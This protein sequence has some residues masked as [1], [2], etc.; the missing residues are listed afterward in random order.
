M[1]P[2]A[3]KLFEFTAQW[4][5]ETGVWWCSND[6][7]PVTTEAPTFDELVARVMEIAPEMAEVNG[8]ARSGEQ[9]EIRVVAERIQSVPVPAAA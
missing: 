7:L 9:I 6:E 2:S 8:L 4:D 3:K 1:A 5:P